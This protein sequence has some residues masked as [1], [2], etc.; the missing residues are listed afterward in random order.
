M[1]NNGFC[2]RAGG[3]A[4]RAYRFIA[5]NARKLGRYCHGAVDCLNAPALEPEP[6][7][8]SQSPTPRPVCA[9]PPATT[10]PVELRTGESVYAPEE[11]YQTKVQAQANLEE[12]VANLEAAGLSVTV[13][14]VRPAAQGSYALQVRFREEGSGPWPERGLWLVKA[15]SSLGTYPTAG[16]AQAALHDCVSLFSKAGA[17]VFNFAITTRAVGYSFA[18]DYAVRS[19]RTVESPGSALLVQQ[20]SCQGAPQSPP[21]TRIAL[22]RISEALRTAR[23]ALISAQARP[24]GSWPC[25]LSITYLT[26]FSPETFEPALALREYRP[27]TDHS[28]KADAEAARSDR[29][30]A[31]RHAGIA[32]IDSG[33]AIAAPGR[34]SFVLR[35][36]MKR[37]A[38][39]GGFI[40]AFVI[41]KSSSPVFYPLQAVARNV[42]ADSV[43]RCQEAGGS[44][45]H[46]VVTRNADGDYGWSMEYVRRERPSKEN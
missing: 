10:E 9:A 13:A 28:L 37:Q 23:V 43:R 24:E 20:H 1:K 39:N 21:E 14:A 31:F 7:R 36:L 30:Q 18:L 40:D 26:R 19:L 27:A 3:W 5:E 34:T 8:P 45:L 35:Y 12:C 25:A 2:A 11:P 42:L 6:P 15:Y 38:H 4:S 29:L 32:V 46:G 17:T 44:V 16:L 41:E 22:R 33:A